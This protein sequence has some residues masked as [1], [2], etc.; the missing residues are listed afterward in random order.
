MKTVNSIKTTRGLAER[1][2]ASRFPRRAGKAE[3][4]APVRQLEKGDAYYCSILYHSRYTVVCYLE[5]EGGWEE[6]RKEMNTNPSTPEGW[7]LQST[8]MSAN[9][10]R[11]AICCIPKPSE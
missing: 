8:R 9:I 4:V 7:L 10:A 2:V 6:E 3:M 11:K 1:E 5:E